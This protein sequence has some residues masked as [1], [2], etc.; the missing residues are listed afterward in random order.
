MSPEDSRRR[1]EAI[2]RTALA[3]SPTPLL[4]VSALEEALGTAA[5]L[6]LKMD[7]WTGFGL[8][9]N[10]V[11]KLEYE[12]A[13]DAL[14]GVTRLV[15]A[16]GPHSNHCRVAAAAA[17][18]LGLPCT[19]VL[20]GTPEDESRGN[21][22]LHRAYGATIDAVDS[23]ELRAP[24]M[25]EVADEEQRAGGKALV[26]PLGASTPRGA[27]G[28]VR[29]LFELADQTDRAQ[30][31]HIVVSSSSGGT[32]AGILAGRVLA[33]W[34][35]TV[36]AVSADDPADEIMTTAMQ[37]AEQALGIMEVQPP[38]SLTEGVT[39]TDRFVGGG[40]GI[41][42]KE[43]DRAAVLFGKHGAT[44]LD[45]YYTAKAGAAFIAKVTSET[46]N[47]SDHVVFLHTGGHPAVFR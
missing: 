23:R 43:S 7:A 4:R 2:G 1:L 30:N 12:L 14:A 5:R 25:L 44:I 46:L 33:D 20:N 31:L 45:P 26:V 35:P 24:R 39:V 15:T 34:Y 47:P 32:L 6:S 13:P 41:A 40:Y 21:A 11:R 9:G 3:V 17:A 42:T 29:S 37:L 16:G 18:Y 10:K 28:Y 38:P 22:R 19:L 27:L 36:T 8:G